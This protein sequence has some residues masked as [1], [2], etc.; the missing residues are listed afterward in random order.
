M[1]FTYIPSA[2]EIAI[3]HHVHHMKSV[4]LHNLLQP[5]TSHFTNGKTEAL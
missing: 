5:L 2:L 1:L 3:T 4:S